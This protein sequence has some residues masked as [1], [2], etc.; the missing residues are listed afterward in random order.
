MS[1]PIEFTHYSRLFTEWSMPDHAIMQVQIR[2]GVTI[3]E[4]V[5]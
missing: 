1:F 5:C 3:W 4:R 2:S